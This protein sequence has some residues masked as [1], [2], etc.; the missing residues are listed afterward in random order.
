MTHFPVNLSYTPVAQSK[1]YLVVGF[2]DLGGSQ[3]IHLPVASRYG[4]VVGHIHL[5]V[6]VS[7]I[8]LLGQQLAQLHCSCVTLK[9]WPRTAKT[10]SKKIPFF[11]VID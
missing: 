6:E 10:A 8:M 2:Q 5:S 11:K 7:S 4:A 1:H 3:A 9:A